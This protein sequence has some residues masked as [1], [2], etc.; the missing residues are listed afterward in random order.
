MPGKNPSNLLTFPWSRCPD[1]YEVSWVH[2]APLKP[3]E[4]VTFLNS[5]QEPYQQIAPLTE[6][7]EEIEPL[8]D[9]GVGIARTFA[10]I[11][12]DKGEL[13][14]DA[15]KHF[16]NR[17]G[18]L[19]QPPPHGRKMEYLES[20]QSFAR[21]VSLVIGAIDLKTAAGNLLASDV[22]NRMD[23]IRVSAKVPPEVNKKRRQIQLQPADLASA[24]WMALSDEIT[25]GVNIQRCLNSRCS[26]WFTFRPSKYY[27]CGACRVAG[28]RQSGRVA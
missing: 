2:P 22:Y 17:Y 18:L 9:L 12:N 23:A 21:N 27:C 13:D 20:W 26:N 15:V 14:M 25:A 7:T 1:G 10:G 24:I 6:R 8:A 28:H 5:N 11:L 4:M 3:G 16:S 19:L